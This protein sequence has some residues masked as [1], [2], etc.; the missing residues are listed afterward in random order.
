MLE[1]QTSKLVQNLVLKKVWRE[2][3]DLGDI[4][5]LGSWLLVAAQNVVKRINIY[6]SKKQR[7]THVTATLLLVSSYSHHRPARCE[8]NPNTHN[9]NHL[10]RHHRF[11]SMISK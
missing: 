3:E 2:D 8:N 6:I 1:P 5:N 4:K 7:H 10:H 9:A 11:G